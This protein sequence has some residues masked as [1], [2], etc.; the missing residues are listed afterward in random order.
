[1][2]LSVHT[3]RYHYAGPDRLDVTATD[4]D[5]IGSVFSPTWSMVFSWKKGK[6][7]WSQYKRAYRELLFRSEKEHPE[8]WADV[9]SRE[10]IVLVCFCPA[11]GH[12]HRYELATWLIHRY[13]AT[14]FG[15]VSIKY[16]HRIISPPPTQR[17]LFD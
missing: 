12:C 11:F 13:G 3:A 15:E 16:P 8:E 2:S 1:M 7:T 4:K 6:W 17:L 5:P 9:L 10:R 14:Y